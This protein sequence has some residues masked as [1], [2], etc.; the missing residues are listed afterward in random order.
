MS[1]IALSSSD[2]ALNLN[3][4]GIAHNESNLLPDLLFT[5]ASVLFGLEYLNNTIANLC[6]ELNGRCHPTPSGVN[7][8]KLVT[9]N[10]V[11]YITKAWNSDAVQPNNQLI[12]LPHVMKAWVNNFTYHAFMSTSLV[13]AN[14]PS[15]FDCSNSFTTKEL[16]SLEVL[17]SDFHILDLKKQYAQSKVN[18]L[19]EAIMCIAEFHGNDNSCS[20]FTPSDLSA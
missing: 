5:T 18:M 3:V 11:C 12:P 14:G 9:P 20:S 10:A 6:E 4:L 16:K 1:N 19:S 2:T 8:E 15:C 13:E 7:P 17:K